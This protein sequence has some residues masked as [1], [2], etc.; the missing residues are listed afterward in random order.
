MAS[1]ENKEMQCS[2]KCMYFPDMTCTH[3]EYDK[4][5]PNVKRRV[6]GKVFKCE[7]DKHIITSW[8]ATCPRQL[9]IMLR[10]E[11]NKKNE[12]LEE[13]NNND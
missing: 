12:L 11:E 4:E 10:E 7:Y 8:Y 5:I 13:E 6:D 1:E 3:W 9:D 2:P